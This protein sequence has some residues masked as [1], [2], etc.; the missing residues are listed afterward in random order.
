M[1]RVEQ[2]D[3]FT[4]GVRFVCGALIGMILGFGAVASVNELPLFVGSIAAGTLVGGFLAARY[5]RR[6][7]GWLRHL[8]W[9]PFP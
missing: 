1:R 9:F 8:Q 7:L 4:I 6:F 5:G 3:Y 2:P